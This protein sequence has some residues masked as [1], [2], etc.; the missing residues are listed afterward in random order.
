MTRRLSVA[1][2]ATDL[3]AYRAMLS[4]ES[5]QQSLTVS[6][7]D[8]SFAEIFNKAQNQVGEDTPIETPRVVS[9]MTKRSN[10][11]SESANEYFRRAIFLPYID[12]VLSQLS[13]RFENQKIAWKGLFSLV[14][15]VIKTDQ[16]DFT[17]IEKLSDTYCDVIPGSKE[18]LVAEVKRWQQY[19]KSES[20]AEIPSTVVGSLKLC[21]EMV[22]YPNVRALLKVLA[23]LPVTTCTAE[24]SFSAL[25]HIKSYLR[26]TMTEV[27]LN[28]LAALFIHK[29]IPLDKEG[30]LNEFSK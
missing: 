12:T 20:V 18:E 23:T 24:R 1:L 3:D 19:F 28:G 22:T 13:V 30:V 7:D 8:S 5:S 2:Q 16:L 6:R 14:P 17:D 25:K 9:R 4:V 21:Q 15:A 26:A 10:P 11:P 29:H 27:R